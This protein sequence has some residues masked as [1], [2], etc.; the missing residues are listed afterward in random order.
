MVVVVALAAPRA[1]AE[2]KTESDCNIELGP[3]DLFSRSGN[4]VVE[5]GKRVDAVIALD[6]DVLIKKGAR[7]KNIIAVKGSVRIESGA[8]VTDDVLALAG[9]ISIAPDAKVKGSQ[10]SLDR[11][12]KM[13]D[14]DGDSAN[15]DIDLNGKSLAAMFAGPLVEKLRDCRVVERADAKR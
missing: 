12:L 15:I 3:N 14:A 5:A 8:T 9:K 2:D 10:L 1:R 4:L 13:K 6:G 7:V 11:S